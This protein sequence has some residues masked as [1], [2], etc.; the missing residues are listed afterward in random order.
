MDS[1]HEVHLITNKMPGFGDKY[2]TV[3][4]Y[5]TQEQM[6]ASIATHSDADVF[7]CHNEPSWFVIAVK[8]ELGGKPVI[9][10]VHDSMLIRYAP[11]D[12]NDDHVRVS[13]SERDNMQ[14]ADGLVFVS[15]TMADVCRNEFSLDQPYTVLPSYV[16]KVLYRMDPYKWLGG[17]VY[18]GRTDITEKSKDEG[19]ECFTYADYREVARQLSE[20][21]I[22][23][24]IFSP[25][26]DTAEMQQQYQDHALIMDSKPL[27]EL[28]RAMGSHNWGLLGNL[29][30][31]E[32]WQH[33]MPNK[34]FEYMAAGIPV[35]ALNAKAAGEFVEEHGFGISVS[36]VDE[37]ASRWVEHRPCRRNITMKRNDWC[38]DN[39]IHR[40][41][42]LYKEIL[43]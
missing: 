1:G 37:I 24:Y 22:P 21:G 25:N 43:N 17:I 20:K 28:L 41:T 8:S 40:V 36:S 5:L 33:A 19:M 38:M 32:V 39:H 35:I 26:R 12:D 9:L 10:D 34:L 30:S 16:P 18:E 14:L 23:F 4:M 6:L 13:V 31:H 15:R 29:G 3:Q 2:A 7:H 11:E 27:H 42:D